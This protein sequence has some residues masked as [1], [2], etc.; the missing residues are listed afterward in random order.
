MQ[1]IV[2]VIG[3]TTELQPL[4]DD[5]YAGH[6]PFCTIDRDLSLFIVDTESQTWH[7]HVCDKSGD[8]FSFIM[9]RDG[10]SFKAALAMLRGDIRRQRLTVVK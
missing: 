10:V 1:T 4:G 8:V 7:C 5:S 2:D 6:C 3:K 9:E